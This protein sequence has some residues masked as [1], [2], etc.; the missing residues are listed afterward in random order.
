MQAAL[1][2]FDARGEAPADAVARALEGIDGA[3]AADL[4]LLPELWPVGAFACAQ[5]PAAAEAVDGR[6]VQAFQ[7]RAR[8][9]KAWLH[10]GSFVEL[11]GAARYN[12]SLL[13]NAQGEIVAR[14][15]KIHLFGQA[16]S[17]E[18]QYLSRG[19]EIVVVD[20]PF[21]RAGLSTCYDLRFP[22][23][24][25]RQVAQGA[26]LF[27]VVAGWP[28]KRIDAWN[29]FTRARAAE[30]Q[31]H[32]IACN[33]CGVT[34]EIRLGGH[35][36]LVGPLGEVLAQADDQPATLTVE[37]NPAAAADLRASFS[38]LRDRVLV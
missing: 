11:D 17:L 26:E 10:I 13:I 31:A 29:L 27:L 3:P 25:R 1:L 37:W 35:S 19:S 20:T 5:F 33:G 30:N 28:L 6:T 2:Q 24:Y 14:Y 38:A 36:Q 7:E 4:Y 9:C 34:G 12:T 23:L 18:P 15:R 21:G 8:R 32:L 16:G 22:E